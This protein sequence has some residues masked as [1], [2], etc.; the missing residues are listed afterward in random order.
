MKNVQSEKNRIEFRL[1]DDAQLTKQFNAVLKDV[2]VLLNPMHT[3]MG[4]QEKMKKRRDY[5][6]AKKRYYFSVSNAKPNSAKLELNGLQY[7][8][9]DS[10]G[11]EESIST[12]QKTYILKEFEI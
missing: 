4:N 8:I 10:I 3:P 9:K 1:N 6:S 11:L 5:L 2:D 12:L 7:A